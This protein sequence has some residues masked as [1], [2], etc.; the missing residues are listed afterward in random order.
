MLTANGGWLMP[1]GC[2]ALVP[3]NCF[4]GVFGLERHVSPMFNRFKELH[5]IAWSIPATLPFLDT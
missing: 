3:P 5:Q 2:F 4:P 1:G